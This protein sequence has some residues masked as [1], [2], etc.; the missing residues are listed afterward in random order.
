M[1]DILQWVAAIGAG[2]LISVLNGV[3]HFI[4]NK[5]IKESEA[6]RVEFEVMK[7]ELEYC[8]ESIQK[9]Y[10]ELGIREE[11]EKTAKKELSISETKRYKLKGCISK[12]HGCTYADNCPVLERQR[13]LETE[14]QK[15][16]Q[17]GNEERTD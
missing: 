5:K 11:S 8:K 16:L 7:A 9:V 12:A 6:R 15:T 10:R 4:P 2:S 17:N 14:Y 3:F 1:W 13:E